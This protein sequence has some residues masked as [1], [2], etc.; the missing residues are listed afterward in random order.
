[1]VEEHSSGIH[2]TPGLR[3]TE[4]NCSR[5][6]ST[7]ALEKDQKYFEKRKKN[8]LAAKKSR[9][10]KKFRDDQI[11]LKAYVLE[12]EVRVLKSHL[13]NLIEENQI[14]L[15]ILYS[16]TSASKQTILT[17]SQASTSF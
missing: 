14:L 17:N 15:F 10:A 1:M 16:L 13:E 12:E 4:K 11:A 8:N 2:S 9:D 3:P 7:R 5:K 6:P